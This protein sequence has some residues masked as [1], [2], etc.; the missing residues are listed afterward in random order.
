MERRPNKQTSPICFLSCEHCTVWKC[1]CDMCDCDMC[2]CLNCTGVY[3]RPLC[4]FVFVSHCV[5]V[6]VCSV[7]SACGF[8]RVCI[9]AHF[10]LFLYVSAFIYSHFCV[11]LPA[12]VLGSLFMCLCVCVLSGGVGNVIRG[13]GGVCLVQTA[14]VCVESDISILQRE[15]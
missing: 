9:P 6:C 14:N 7:L 11:C 4:I 13:P 10:L 3:V 1:D 8:V 5:F 2:G 12:Y 15:L